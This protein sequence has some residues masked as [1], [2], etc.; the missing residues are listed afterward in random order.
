M[1]L[2]IWRYS[3]LAL[4]VLASLFIF[5][6]SVTGIILAFESAYNQTLP[7]KSADFQEVTLSET[8]VRLKEKYPEILSLSVDKNHFVKVEALDNEGNTV[9]AYINPKTAE[10]ISG[11]YKQAEIFKF[12]KTLH[13]SL[14][15]GKAGR[16]M[17]DVAAFFFFCIALSGVMLI[18]RKQKSWKRF[19]HKIV[20]EKFFNH[21]HTILGRILL[22]PILIISFTGVY[23]GLETLSVV[24]EFKPTHHID[25]QLL[26][27]EPIK[28]IT[29]FQ[30]FN[31]PLSEVEKVEFP[32]FEDVEEFYKVTLIDK[33]II[34]NQFTGEIIS[35]AGHWTK[36]M[37]H[38]SQLLHVGQGNF[39]W[40]VVLLLSCFAILFFIYSGFAITLKRS[41]SVIKNFYKKDEC[42]Y[43]ILVGSEGGST[44]RFAK[45]IHNE[46][47]RKGKKA[48]LAEMNSFSSFEKMEHLLILTCTYGKGDAPTNALK[49]SELYRKNEIKKPFTYSVVGFGSLAYPDFCKF[50]F[51]VENLLKNTSLATPLTDLYTVNN[52]AF[53]VFS[54]WVNLWA[55][56]QNLS[57]QLSP[58]SLQGKK[59]KPSVF[60]VIEKTEITADETFLVKL[61]PLD[62]KSFT[63]GDLLAITP[64]I[65]NRERLYSIG[66]I[67]KNRIILSIKRHEKGIVSNYLN[68]L[69]SK[70]YIKARLQ[71]NPEFHFPR[72]AKKVV[73][74]A[75]GT[76]IAPFLGMIN[77]NQKKT[78]I[79]LIWGGKNKQ[80]F[81]VYE[82]F[83]SENIQKGRLEKLHLAFSRDKNKQYV[84]DIVNL[85]AELFANLL[86]SRGVIMI[87]GSVAMQKG[88]METLENICQTRLKKS[89]SHFQN[90]KQILM[91]CY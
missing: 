36:K 11:D 50:A 64:E 29:D 57:L 9:S 47:L 3:H 59:Q 68:G 6:A 88:V 44:L 49:F 15:M 43:I 41:K 24:K 87:C 16:V 26:T 37:A 25:N 82:E 70:S 78:P 46:L 71:R 74:I 56:R 5:I 48:F 65:D 35:E 63:S 40:A 39:I 54:E 61:Q 10:T 20:K 4:S 51:E 17:M 21:Y 34:V 23:M 76:G 80:S 83:I 53:E 75:T 13:R 22:I 73:C 19:F 7:F 1:T 33:E 52:Q 85:Q 38:Y 91:D 89:V 2:S 12:S 27:E 79:T 8:I 77:E 86:I 60:Q 32:A 67:E 58:E 90:R 72:K 30:A 45:L 55:S 31:I 66:K 84:Q 28:K 69:K 14:F 62:N 18:V 81:S 42:Q